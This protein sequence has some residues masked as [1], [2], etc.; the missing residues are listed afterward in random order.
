[1]LITSSNLEACST[2]SS[3]TFAV[4]SMFD[5]RAALATSSAKA[6]RLLALRAA[7]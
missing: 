2:G 7:V 5:G 1:M 6:W 4:E 3:A